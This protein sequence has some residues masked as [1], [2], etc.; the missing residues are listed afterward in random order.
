MLSIKVLELA[1]ICVGEFVVGKKV[2]IEV[3]H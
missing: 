3:P 2:Y 1:V